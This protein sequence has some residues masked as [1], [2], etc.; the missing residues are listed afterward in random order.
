MGDNKMTIIYN[1]YEYT[2]VKPESGS[3]SFK[4]YE[5]TCL[6]KLK[7]QMCKTDTYE[8]LFTTYTFIYSNVFINCLCRMDEGG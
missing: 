2:V 1:G 8:K 5:Y 6:Y 3:D 7:L 4:D